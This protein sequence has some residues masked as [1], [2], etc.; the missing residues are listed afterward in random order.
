M[1]TGAKTGIPVRR[2]YSNLMRSNILEQKTRGMLR[3]SDSG[4]I[5]KMQ[6]YSVDD[7]LNVAYD[8]GVEYANISSRWQ[9]NR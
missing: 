4:Y 2:L 7:S 1:G 5:L 8:R 3:W 9:S 6:Q